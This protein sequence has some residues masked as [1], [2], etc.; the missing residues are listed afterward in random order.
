MPTPGSTPFLVAV[1]NAV[2]WNRR[3]VA[4]S[5]N[6]FF[7][8]IGGSISVAAL[9]AVLN[10]HLRAVLGEGANANAVLDPA[11][12]QAADPLTLFR[13]VTALAQGLHTVF[14]ICLI[15]GVIAVFIAV[16]FPAGRAADHAHEEKVAAVP[17]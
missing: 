10:S 4:T 11:T 16:L 7:R 3:G 5:T 15:G 14:L 17:H 6:Q 13:T 12:R 8:T 9:G 1:Q 2:P